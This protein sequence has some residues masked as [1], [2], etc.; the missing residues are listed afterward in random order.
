MS[1]IKNILWGVCGV[2]LYKIATDSDTKQGSAQLK[3]EEVP[4]DFEAQFSEPINESLV[5]YARGP[6]RS[7]FDNWL[8]HAGI[9]ATSRDKDK[10][11]ALWKLYRL[12]YS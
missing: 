12:R 2:A 7:G 1:L 3:E 8:R 11:D 10:A 4:P 9:D 6:L 5:M